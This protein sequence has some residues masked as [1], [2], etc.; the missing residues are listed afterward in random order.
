[1]HFPGAMVKVAHGGLQAL[2]MAG[3]QMPHA[4]VLDLEMPELDGEQLAK[5]L[6]NLARGAPPFLIA[7]SGNITR[8]AALNGSGV[9][10]HL[11]SKPVDL[12]TLVRV[13]QAQLKPQAGTPHST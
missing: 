2:A 11:L 5:E 10:D 3:S 4:A 12:Q 9:F 13:L 1:M 7:L 6:Q 8:L